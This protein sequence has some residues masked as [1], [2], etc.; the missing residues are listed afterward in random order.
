M[1]ITIQTDKYSFNEAFEELQRVLPDF[2]SKYATT[3]HEMQS[4]NCMA[5]TFTDKTSIKIIHAQYKYVGHA[6]VK[7]VGYTFIFNI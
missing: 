4:Y 6:F 3:L 1:K 5:W 7:Q 2:S